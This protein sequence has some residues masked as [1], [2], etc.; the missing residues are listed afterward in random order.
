MEEE[1][2][3]AALWQKI[4][5]SELSGEALAYPCDQKIGLHKGEKDYLITASSQI[6]VKDEE[7]GTQKV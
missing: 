1:S 2:Q 6:I 4:I 7:K 5:D 3:V